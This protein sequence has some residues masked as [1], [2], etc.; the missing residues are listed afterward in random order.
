MFMT[1]NFDIRCLFSLL[2]EIFG[3]NVLSSVLLRFKQLGVEKKQLVPSFIK[4]GM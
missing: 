3:L 1:I 4:C 2:V